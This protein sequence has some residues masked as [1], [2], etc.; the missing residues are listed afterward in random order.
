MPT[1][2]WLGGSPDI[3]W[4]RGRLVE[5]FALRPESGAIVRDLLFIR[6]DSLV[7]MFKYTKFK[8]FIFLKETIAVMDSPPVT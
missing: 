3:P 5:L 7:L 2:A 8:L 6:F 4:I 1:D